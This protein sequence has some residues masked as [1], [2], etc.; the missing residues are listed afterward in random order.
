M[1]ER[2]QELFDKSF[3]EV[4]YSIDKMTFRPYPDTEGPNSKWE[5]NAEKFAKLIVQECSNT[6]LHYTNVDE[7]AAVMRK[8]FGVEE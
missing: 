5:F 1:N 8:N 3:D 6:V 2:I 4:R 7:G